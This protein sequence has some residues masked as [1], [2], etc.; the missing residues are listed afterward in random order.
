MRLLWLLLVPVGMATAQPLTLKQ[1]VRRALEN[2][3][4][5]RI[6]EAQQ[7]KAHQ[8]WREAR[9]QFVP[10]IVVGSGLAGT[11]GF[12]L[13]IEGAAPSLI[14]VN[15]TALLF[16]R[17]QKHAANEAKLTWRAAGSAVHAR[18]DEVVWKTAAAYLEL[19]KVR[20]SLEFARR[21]G[22]STRRIEQAVAAQV[23]E[24]RE[25][26]LEL[27]RARLAV[28]R[29][30][31][32]LGTLEGQAAVLEVLLRGLTGIP[33]GDSIEPVDA[34]LPLSDQPE[35]TAAEVTV[36]QALAVHPELRRL[37]LEVEARE[38][39]VRSERA[40]R[41]PQADLV[42][43][44]ALL[45]RANNYHRFFKEF[46]R[47]NAQIGMA[48][49]FTIFD[50]NR[51]NAR[52]AQAEADLM[53][54]RATLAAARND[55]ALEVRRT[56]L[57]VKQREAACQVA[58]LELDVAREALTIALARFNEGRISIRE[59]EQARTE[60]SARWLGFLDADFALE[61]ARLDLLR[62]TGDLMAALR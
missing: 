53:Q 40:Q 47:H 29:N 15:S 24:G 52:V 1:A 7:E 44:Y 20:R 38:A 46:E 23:A 8:A 36:E 45:T 11:R 59:L 39:R 54:A 33:A 13:S 30:V 22:E 2:S 32:T 55:V 61:R 6:L 57:G 27:T 16:N 10:D 3:P 62:H 18:A 12:P 42:G 48:L 50:G 41:W 58:R 14:Q 31:Q 25:I 35:A 26:P 56:L 19:N 37:A 5:L 43:Q 34:S 60:E 9:A 17:P 49:R 51:I 4:E 28:A 21:E